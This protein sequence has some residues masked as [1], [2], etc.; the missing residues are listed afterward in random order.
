MKITMDGKDYFL[1]DIND[2]LFQKLLPVCAPNCMATSFGRFEVIYSVYNN[3]KYIVQNEI[4]GDVVE[5]GVWKGGLMQLAA[6]T[7]LELGDTSRKIYL[8][9]TFEGMPEP[10]VFDKDW[11]DNSPHSKWESLRWENDASLGSR[12]GFGG[13]LEI[14]RSIMEET[15]Y[16][17][18]NFVF[19]KGLVEETIP[20]T[21]PTQ[22]ACLRLDTD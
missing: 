7:L 22:I 8:Y 20:A 6:L 13:S 3:I 16:P 17:S 1:N 4:P 12:F 18:D 19:V 11:N 9:D 10:G 15:K 14:V 21:C 5:C 2:E